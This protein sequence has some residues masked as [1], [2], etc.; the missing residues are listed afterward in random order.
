[1]ATD[2]RR[3]LV[4]AGDVGGTNARLALFETGGAVLREAAL[5]TL[6][7]RG[8]AAFEEILLEFRARHPEPVAAACV[9]IAGPVVGGRVAASNLP[10]T[11]DAARIAQILGLQRAELI[12]DLEANALG[13]AAL[14][15]DD[16]AV[17]REGKPDPDGNGAL[18]SAGTGLGEAGLRRGPD[19]FLPIRSE[20]GHADFAP[21]GELQIE[22]LNFLARQF[23]HASWERVLSGPGLFNVY[24]FLKETGRG[25]EPAWLADELRG[26]DPP[27]VVARAAEEG[28]S[29]LCDAAVELFVALYGAEAGNLALKF[30]ATAGVYLGGGIAPRLLS[31]LRRPAFLQAFS[32]KGRL[33]P[34]L[35][36]MPVRV[37]LA[38]KT[39]LL[40]AARRAASAA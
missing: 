19:G 38:D 8:R 7:S 4:L 27:A 31:R 17:L 34:L 30:L 2:G 20:G 33:K 9:G 24:R 23:G 36:D 26:G 1:M 11:A 39:A 18:I 15:P 13:I 32:D 40:G 5:E 29:E 37:I 22:L 16:V 6:P 10:W 25:A 28:K 12:N 35:E 3:R 21:R 14:G